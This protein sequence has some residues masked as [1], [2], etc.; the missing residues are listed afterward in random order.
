MHVTV[1]PWFVSR[2]RVREQA[3]EFVEFDGASMDPEIMLRHCHIFFTRRQLFVDVIFPASLP[4][5]M[6]GIKMATAVSWTVVVAAELVAAQRGLGYVIMDAATFFR[7]PDLYI[8][9]AA[10]GAI[11]FVL[12][13]IESYIERSL[14]HWSGK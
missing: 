6:T 11:G 5:V 4:H 1:G 9:I 14:L 2:R 10:I 8:G 12:E 7:I 3:N 13:T